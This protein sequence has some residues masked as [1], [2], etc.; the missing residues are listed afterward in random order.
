MDLEVNKFFIVSAHRE[1]NVDSTE[2]LLDLL[3][4]LN[5]L[6]ETYDC[7]VIVSTH[8]RTQAM[9]ILSASQTCQG[10][11]LLIA[12]KRMLGVIYYQEY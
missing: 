8:P 1:E 3:E 2:N 5:G 9:T 12:L 7:P 10:R 6:A 11:S 4:T